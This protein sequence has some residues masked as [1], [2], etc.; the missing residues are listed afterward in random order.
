MRQL[1]LIPATSCIAWADQPLCCLQLPGSLVQQ[2]GRK[3]LLLWLQCWQLSS[4]E[5]LS[6]S[7]HYTRMLIELWQSGQ[8]LKSLRRWGH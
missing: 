2:Q 4:S 5:R 3:M 7:Q 1:S 6:S 8:R